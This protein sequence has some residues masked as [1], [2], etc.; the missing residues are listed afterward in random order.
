MADLKTKFEKAAA[1]VQ[2]LKQK[3]DNDTLLKLY[4][5]YKQ[6]SAGELAGKRP[7]FTDF[8][9]RAKYDAWAK[10]QGTSQKKAMEDYIS[11][12]EKLQG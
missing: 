2:K 9:G 3:P 5:L 12:V 1:D 11:L 4:A 6:G 10:L 8:K 7:G